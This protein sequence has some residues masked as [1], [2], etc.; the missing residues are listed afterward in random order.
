MDILDYSFDNFKRT[1]FRLETLNS[2]AIYDT[3]EYEEF[4]NFVKE[5]PITGFANQCWLDDIAKWKSEGK[6]IERI[7][8]IPKELTEYFM[9]EF[10][11]C[12]PRNIEV[13]E[14]IRFV[15]WKDYEQVVKRFQV[16][17]DFWAF[18]DS[19]VIILKYNSDFEYEDCE[20]IQ[21]K[22]ESKKYISM[23]Q[24]LKEKTFTYD[25]VIL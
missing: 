3:N 7:R 14:G 8:V 10:K 20:E 25:S 18:D 13:G 2:Y 1:G 9:Y 24:A 15:S 16:K 22:E 23:F 5:Q 4:Q 11:W 17:G 19:T 21:G 12:Y 6:S